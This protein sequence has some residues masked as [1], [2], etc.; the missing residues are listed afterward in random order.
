MRLRLAFV[1]LAVLATNVVLLGPSVAN[2]TIHEE[3]MKQ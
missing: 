1:A 3:K 2:P